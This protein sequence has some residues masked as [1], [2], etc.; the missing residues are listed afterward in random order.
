MPETTRSLPPVFVIVKDLA[1]V[2]A[3]RAVLNSSREVTPRT[4]SA[5]DTL[6]AGE[7]GGA[8]MVKVDCAL[9]VLPAPS[10]A[11]TTTVCDPAPLTVTGPVE[12]FG[13][14]LSTT[15]LT[16]AAPVPRSV[17]SAVTVTGPVNAGLVPGPAAVSSAFGFQVSAAPVV[18]RWS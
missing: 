9:A 11:V 7:P 12:D 17:V 15:E 16:D 13:A 3:V 14:P 6:R 8:W 18:V 4:S 2:A 5:S 1:G 10:V